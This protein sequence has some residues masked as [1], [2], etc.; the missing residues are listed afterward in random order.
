MSDE[1]LAAL[2]AMARRILERRH[3]REAAERAQRRRRLR[4][5]A[6]DDAA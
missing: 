5:V 6:K 3:A 1:L 2:L 4:V